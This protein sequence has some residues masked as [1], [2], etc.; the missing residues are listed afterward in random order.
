MKTS[1]ILLQCIVMLGNR[2]C[3]H[4]CGCHSHKLCR[5]LAT[6]SLT[7]QQC[8]EMAWWM[9]SKRQPCLQIPQISIR[10]SICGTSWITSNPW[11]PH[12]AIPRTQSDIHRWSLNRNC[13]KKS[14]RCSIRLGFRNL[15]AGLTPWA[16]SWGQSWTVLV[17]W[18]DP[19][20]CCGGHCHWVNRCL[21]DNVLVSDLHMNVRSQ[22]FPSRTFHCKKMVKVVDFSRQWF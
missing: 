5:R 20:S 8:T 17:V 14:H 10:S 2:L 22:A 9:R 3:W 6:A 1:V 12:V 11:M 16:L 4:S 15:E 13:F 7:A 19:L 21:W 18:K